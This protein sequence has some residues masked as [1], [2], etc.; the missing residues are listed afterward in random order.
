M[1]CNTCIQNFTLRIGAV[2]TLLQPWDCSLIFLDHG[3]IDLPA[4]KDLPAAG[5]LNASTRTD[6]KVFLLLSDSVVEPKP[7]PVA[8]SPVFSSAVV[9]YPRLR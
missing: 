5:D 7:G 2:A 1:N 4:L 6:A 9:I 8:W 3:W